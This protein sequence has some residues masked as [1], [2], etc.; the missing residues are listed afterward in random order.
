[1][2][3][4]KAGTY[5]QYAGDASLI[6]VIF[7]DD[8]KMRNPTDDDIRSSVGN[9]VLSEA[10]AIEFIAKWQAAPTRKPCC[11]F[12]RDY[13]DAPDAAC[14]MRASV[15]EGTYT[16][17]ISENRPA[18]M[19]IHAPSCPMGKNPFSVCTCTG[20][21]T[22]FATRTFTPS[23]TLNITDSDSDRPVKPL[24]LITP[25]QDAHRAL[26]S[27]GQH[28]VGVVIASGV[29]IFGADTDKLGHSV[30]VNWCRHCRCLY[31]EKA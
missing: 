10:Q 2:G 8:V 18:G 30:V 28:E 6:A 22:D 4:P 13:P 7:G 16:D 5:L 31:A 14:R 23:W 17:P 19:V 9:P 26:C 25:E 24:A 27:I 3:H 15:G 21:N 20:V 12:H 1:M 29:P 11:D